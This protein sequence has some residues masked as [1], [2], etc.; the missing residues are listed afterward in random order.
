MFQP[1]TTM[2]DEQKDKLMVAILNA[3]TNCKT[4][5]EKAGH[6]T[7]KMSEKNGGHWS[8]FG[9]DEVGLY[10][11]IRSD[12]GQS[13]IFDYDGKRWYVF[14]HDP[15]NQAITQSNKPGDIKTNMLPKISFAAVTEMDFKIKEQ[16]LFAI[17]T[18]EKNKFVGQSKLCYVGKKM[19]NMY[20]GTWTIIVYNGAGHWS[21]CGQTSYYAVFEHE[22]KHWIVYKNRIQ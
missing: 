21:L 7:K 17:Y 1:E 16:L 10:V 3:E 22:G 19:E 18:A 14:R 4:G 8:A 6:I 20:G 12:L 5:N 15:T 9:V 2:S 13:A 11:Y